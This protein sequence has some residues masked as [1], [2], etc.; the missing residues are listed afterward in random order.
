MKTMKTLNSF[1]LGN[2]RT[3]VSNTTYIYLFISKIKSVLKFWKVMWERNKN[4]CEGGG[5]FEKAIEK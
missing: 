4:N 2:M 1:I 5:D 3:S